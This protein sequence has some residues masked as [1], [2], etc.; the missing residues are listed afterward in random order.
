MN[1]SFRRSKRLVARRSGAAGAGAPAA[2]A[3]EKELLKAQL[4]KV[5]AERDLARNEYLQKRDE[6]DRY[7]AER[8]H[9]QQQ[10]DEARVGHTRT[11]RAAEDGFNL[12]AGRTGDVLNIMDSVI[13]ITCMCIHHVALGALCS[14]VLSW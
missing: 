8:D 11:E 6:C 12:L 5:T 10:L 3:G 13:N 9:L 4:G 7:K 1:L 14:T 2:D